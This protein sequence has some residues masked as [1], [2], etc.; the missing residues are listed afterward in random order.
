MLENQSVQSHL[1]SE[2]RLGLNITIIQGASIEGRNDK[3]M[4]DLKAGIYIKS[5]YALIGSVFTNTTL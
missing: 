4:M 1:L 5:T 3:L 2:I